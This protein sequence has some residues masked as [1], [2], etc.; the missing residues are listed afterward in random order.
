MM[1]K[2]SNEHIKLLFSTKNTDKHLDIWSEVSTK[3]VKLFTF[4]VQKI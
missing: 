2:I 1:P 3:F 4:V